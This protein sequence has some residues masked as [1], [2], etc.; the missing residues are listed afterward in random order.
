V[1]SLRTIAPAALVAALAVAAVLL[2]P[3]FVGNER[4]GEG[5]SVVAH[6]SLDRG[7]ENGDLWFHKGFVYVGDWDYREEGTCPTTLREGVAII[8]ARNRE[9][10]KE[11]GRLAVEPGTWTEDVQVYQAKFGSR[12]GRDIAVAGVQVCGGPVS[13]YLPGIVLWDVSN[14]LRPRRIGRVHTG[15]CTTG[16]H[17]LAVAHRP[18]LRR[19]FVYATV[20][21]SE[22]ARPSAPARP[23]DRRGRGDL[24][25]IDV[26]DPSRPRE[27]SSWGQAKDLGGTPGR[28][29]GCSPGSF[30]H[31]AEP[32]DNGRVVFLS[33]WDSGFIAVDVTNPRQPTYRGRTSYPRTADGDAH[34]ASYDDSRRL[35]F[36]A[37]EDFCPQRHGRIEPGYGYLRVYDYS[38]LARPRQ[39]GE[40]KSAGSRRAAFERD[41]FYTIHNPIVVGG[42][43]YAAWYTDGVRVIDVRN[44]RAPREVAW[45]DGTGT[46]H[47]P[48]VWG[49]VVDQRS[50]QLYA[51][52][53]S[54]G[55][56]ILKRDG[57]D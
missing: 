36:T 32:S 35:L 11:V 20:P 42:E 28:L 47:P 17:S 1:R 24:R 7:R 8:D 46:V 44:P 16:V 51:S 52:D 18:D 29:R 55:L 12:A 10:P 15:C 54:S 45:F 3:Q 33:Y 30:A 27:V 38:R 6:L 40:F 25:I 22:H 34:A 56:W 49:V 13:E 4:D 43:V 50:R 19:T 57:A 5:I 39:I 21:E 23:I 9:E 14:P 31:A 53:M 2:V 37:D 41:A 48:R 26:T